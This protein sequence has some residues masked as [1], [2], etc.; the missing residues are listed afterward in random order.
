MN[1]VDV[2]L[3][4]EW[5]ENVGQCAGYCD[6]DYAGDLDK[7]PSMTGYVFTLA[8]APVSWKSTL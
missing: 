6:S 4:F 7:R 1:T 8:K 2:E 5:N 3:I